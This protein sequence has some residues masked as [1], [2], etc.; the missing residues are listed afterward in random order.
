MAQ[1]STKPK[2]KTSFLTLPHELLRQILLEAPTRKQLWRT[3]DA[4]RERWTDTLGHIHPDILNDVKYVEKTWIKEHAELRHAPQYFNSPDPID[5]AIICQRENTF[6]VRIVYGF[7]D[8][9]YNY[10]GKQKV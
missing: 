2:P 6:Y 10:K 3:N 5:G 7:R 9:I 1:L 4:E 8:R